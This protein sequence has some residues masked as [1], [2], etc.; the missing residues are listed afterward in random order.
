LFIL[1]AVLEKGDL[2]G[3]TTGTGK[4]EDAQI[5]R[6]T[7][8]ING[9]VIYG[10]AITMRC[11]ECN[12]FETY[13]GQVIGGIDPYEKFGRCRELGYTKHVEDLCECAENPGMSLKPV[14]EPVVDLEYRSYCI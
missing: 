11:Q 4:E 7:D 8:Q 12:Q 14:D 2:V 10:R 3:E 5:C 9:I 1:P 6:A 13:A